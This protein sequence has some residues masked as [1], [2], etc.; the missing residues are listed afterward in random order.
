MEAFSAFQAAYG[1]EIPHYDISRQKPELSA[2]V[3]TVVTFGGKAAT[4][5]YPRGVNIVYPMS[6]GLLLKRREHASTIKI[7]LIPAISEVLSGLKEIQPGVKQLTIFW[8]AGRYDSLAS[9][10]RAAGLAMGI[11]V[12]TRKIDDPDTLPS[13]LREEMG[14]MQAFFLPPDPLLV[15]PA[16]LRIFREFS[17]NNGIP[18]YGVTKGMTR[19]G[20][21]AS[22]GV[23]FP[24]MGQT[25]A[26]VVR[27]L[28]A[29]QPVPSIVYPKADEITLNASAARRCG[30]TFPRHITDKADFLFP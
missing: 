29:G 21:V 30:V 11:E 7:S 4:W 15:T 13:F 22:I 18:F 10:A 17:W 6:P 14:K 23:S 12:S 1:S 8:T 26:E 2:A 20:A 5:R 19:E 25:A 16:N 9:E 28:N 24:G 3:R 27:S